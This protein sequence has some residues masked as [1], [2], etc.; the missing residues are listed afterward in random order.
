[1]SN[2]TNAKFV[3]YQKSIN[4][5]AIILY[6]YNDGVLSNGR[7]YVLH[8]ADRRPNR[9]GGDQR[10]VRPAPLGY[11]APGSAAAGPNATAN[12]TAH[13]ALAGALSAA[14][15]RPTLNCAS[16]PSFCTGSAMTVDGGYTAGK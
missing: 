11:A 5:I 3:K 4:N 7:W 12:S 6:A 1:L 13:A 10:R 9:N 14:T 2:Q 16:A 8:S 15:P